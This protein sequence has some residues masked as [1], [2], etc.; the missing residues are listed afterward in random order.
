MASCQVALLRDQLTSETTARIEAQSR[1]HQLLNSNRELLE[2]IQAL[3]GRLQN[4]ETKITQEIH[5]PYVSSPNASFFNRLVCL[6][7]YGTIEAP[8]TGKHAK[9][10]GSSVHLNNNGSSWRSSITICD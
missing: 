8:N 10:F 5:N 1:T 7:K 2:Q 3:V 9:H 6:G 4:L